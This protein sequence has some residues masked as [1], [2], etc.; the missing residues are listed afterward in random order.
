MA[1][2]EH[3][4]KVVC[5]KLSFKIILVIIGNRIITNKF[6]TIMARIGMNIASPMD[7]SLIFHEIP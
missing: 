5:L 3:N 6:I 4:N 7:N 1:V 2:I